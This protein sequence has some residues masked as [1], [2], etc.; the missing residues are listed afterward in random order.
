MDGGGV[1][2]HDGVVVVGGEVAKSSAKHQ[3]FSF[4]SRRPKNQIEPGTHRNQN[5]VR[6]D[7]EV[8]H[9]EDLFRCADPTTRTSNNLVNG[10]ITNDH[11]QSPTSSFKKSL[12]QPR[13]P[14][15]LC[16]TAADGRAMTPVIVRYNNNNSSTSATSGK[17]N[18]NNNSNRPQRRSHSN[19]KDN[20]AYESNEIERR[21]YSPPPPPPVAEATGRPRSRKIQVQ[22]CEEEARDTLNDLKSCPNYSPS[23]FDKRPAYAEYYKQATYN[24]IAMSACKS[25]LRDKLLPPPPVPPEKALQPS[26]ATTAQAE[27]YSVVHDAEEGP[28]SQSNNNNNNNYRSNI[29]L[30]TNC[31][32]PVSID[33]SAGVVQRPASTDSLARQALM[34][35]QVLHLIPTERARARSIAQGTSV[36]C[37]NTLLGI[38]ELNRILP[39]REVKIF[40]GTWNMNGEPPP[41]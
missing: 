30:N 2:D 19:Y 12:F 8:P 35:A 24:S 18:N 38:S 5:H 28:S 6:E 3:I 4:L 41:M 7:S 31:P 20:L 27:I 37:N 40:V 26:T 25:R 9:T 23:T 29:N 16:C 21:F 13:G 14:F 10:N 15:A 34:A 39:N 33:N 11:P 1:G 36:A 17:S 32:S 22:P